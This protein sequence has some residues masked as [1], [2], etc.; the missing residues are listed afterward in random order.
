MEGD[1][2]AKHDAGGRRLLRTTVWVLEARAARRATGV[3]QAIEAAG[4]VY[5]AAPLH[6]VRIALK[7]LRFAVE[8]N[9]EVKDQRAS[10]DIRLLRNGQALLGRLHDL[11]ALIDYA[12]EMQASRFASD[13]VASRE[14]ASLVR[15][16]ER[17]CRKL[18]A[19]YIRN[20]PRL[21][22]IADGVCDRIKRHTGYVARGDQVERLLA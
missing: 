10:R 3:R 12:R 7:K 8:L 9:A 17:D 13:P 22:A 14:Y 5:V 21:L 6:N 4:T 1:D 11:Q 15:V 16:L 20:S 18:H 2:A 19:Q